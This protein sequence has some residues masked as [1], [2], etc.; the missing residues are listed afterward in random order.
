MSTMMPNTVR[1][2]AHLGH[3][4]TVWLERANSR[5]ELRNFGDRDLRDIGLSRADAN[6]EAT[7]PFWMA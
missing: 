7:K 6:R 1:V 5:N 2:L 3:G 4:F